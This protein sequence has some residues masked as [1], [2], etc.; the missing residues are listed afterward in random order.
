MNF[1]GRR[2]GLRTAATPACR[3]LPPSCCESARSISSKSSS[4]QLVFSVALTRGCRHDRLRFGQRQHLTALARPPPF[5]LASR[6]AVDFVEPDLGTQT[7]RLTDR[8]D[9]RGR[10]RHRL[11]ASPCRRRG[12]VDRS[13]LVSSTT[14]L[15][16]NDDTDEQAFPCP[17]ILRCCLAG[18][19]GVSMRNV[20]RASAAKPS[21]SSHRPLEGAQANDR[22]CWRSRSRRKTSCHD[23]PH[24]SSII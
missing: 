14:R 24:G 13:A 20:A 5:P 2:A 23:G 11:P 15:F 10:D 16:E 22:P 19:G 4:N 8:G 18:S 21:R 9:E 7:S 12:A 6:R 17:C 1:L 3:S